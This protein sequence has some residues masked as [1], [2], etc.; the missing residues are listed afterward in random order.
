MLPVVCC[1]HEVTEVAGLTS[2]SFGEED[3]DRHIVVWKKVKVY[4][5][6]ALLP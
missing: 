1:S 4:L 6:K 2:F 5:D 3:I